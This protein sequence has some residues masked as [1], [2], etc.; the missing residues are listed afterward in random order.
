MADPD[1]SKMAQ[2]K[3]VALSSDANGFVL[4]FPSS[5]VYVKSAATAVPMVNK[6]FMALPLSKSPAHGRR[7]KLRRNGPPQTPWRL[8]KERRQGAA[9]LNGVTARR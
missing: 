9:P 4:R 6:R 7:P 3:T 8:A 5:Y 2:L 1:N